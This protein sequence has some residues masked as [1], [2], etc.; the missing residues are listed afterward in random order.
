M[1][2]HNILMFRVYLSFNENCY[3]TKLI[4]SKIFYPFRMFSDIKNNCKIGQWLKV[5]SLNKIVGPNPAISKKS[6]STNSLLVC[7]SSYS[8]GRSWKCVPV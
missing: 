1:S 4:L 5:Q 3:M 6:I 2:R 8:I 7:D